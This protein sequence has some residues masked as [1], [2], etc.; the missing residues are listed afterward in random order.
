MDQKTLAYDRQLYDQTRFIF[1]WT[2]AC[3]QFR[4]QALM[5]DFFRGVLT[6]EADTI[7]MFDI[8]AGKEP[9]QTLFNEE[10]VKRYSAIG[11][12]RSDARVA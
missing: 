5:L 1:D 7:R 10:A 3:S 2:L 12:A 11:R 4:E 9:M 6:S 8:Y